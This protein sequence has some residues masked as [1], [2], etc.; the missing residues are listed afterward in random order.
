M[1]KKTGKLWIANCGLRIGNCGFRISD[2]VFR[3]ASL[4][5]SR[6]LVIICVICVID[7][8]CSL[9]VCGL[10]YAAD[11]IKVKLTDSAGVSEFA[12][13]DSGNNTVFRVDSDGNTKLLSNAELRLFNVGNTFYGGFKSPALA[14]NRIWT[15]P[16]NYGS[17]GQCLIDSNGAG[18]LAWAS[19]ENALTFNAP[20]ARSVDTIS[21]PAANGSTD[22]YLAAAN[23]TTF[24]GK[25]NALTIN[26]PL[27]RAGNTIDVITGTAPAADNLSLH[28]FLSGTPTLNQIPKWNGANWTWAVDAGEAGAGITTLNGQTGASQTF[29]TPNNTLSIS[30]ATNNHAFS[31]T[32][33][34]AANTALQGSER[35]AA[36]GVA[37][38][39][40]GSQL[41]IANLP[42]G[43]VVL[44]YAD[45][46][47]TAET[48]NSTAETTL[49][50][51]SLPANS[52][53]TIIMEVEACGRLEADIDNKCNFT[54]RFKEAVTTRKTFTW[55]IIAENSAGVDSGG[56]N[57]ATLK[58]SFPG[59]Q[60]SATML[61][62]T[63]QMTLANAAGGLLA[64]SIRVYGVK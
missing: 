27:S 33:G 28:D 25:E 56:R 12:V 54:W 62:F 57:S 26:G 61:S 41:P 42:S 11:D 32:Y 48:T 46:T 6:I 60:A 17:T 21:I 13:Q 49:K 38:L 52:Y 40:A 53:S 10:L 1:V 51:W 5:A 16:L 7:S 58:A 37:P 9:Q 55:R 23:W 47:D 30:S 19:K 24:N 43:A 50:S 64:H 4:T 22:G 2:F 44:L 39:D 59:G 31:V 20:L 3:F 8:L 36:N 29:S 45:E 34:Q 15:L 35:N 14:G 63:G 18:T